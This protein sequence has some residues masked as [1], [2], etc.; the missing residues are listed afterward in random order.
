MYKIKQNREMCIGC[1]SCVAVC[2]ENW[3]MKDDNKS[4]PKKT[5]VKKIGCNQKAAD[6]CPVGIISVEE[7]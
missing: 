1:G 3:E 4:A 2:G 5:E 6:T 7:Q